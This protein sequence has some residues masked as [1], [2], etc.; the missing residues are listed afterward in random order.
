MPRTAEIWKP[1]RGFTGFYEV[2]NLGRVRSLDRK[3]RTV[4]GIWKYKGRDLVAF[5]T[6]TNTKIVCLRKGGTQ[7]CCT[8]ASLVARA[9]GR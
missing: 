8:V 3:V 4:R 1:I 9:F 5:P 7:K 2:S 6:T